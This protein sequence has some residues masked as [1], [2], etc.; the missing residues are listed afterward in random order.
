MLE[1]KQILDFHDSAYNRGQVT[2]ERAADDLVFAWV[3]QW[4]D[5]LLGESQLQ[6][7]GEFNILRK[8]MRQI[9]SDLNANPVQVDFEPVGDN[10]NAADIMDG[11]YRT[12]TRQNTSIEAFDNANQENVV[13]GFGSWELENVQDGPDKQKIRRMPIYESCN[14]VYWDPNAKLKDKSDARWCSVLARYSEDGAADLVEGLTGERPAG[15]P[16]FRYPEESYVFPWVAEDKR[17][18]IGRFYHREVVSYE[19]HVFVDLMGNREEVDDVDFESRENELLAGGFDYHECIECER[20][21]VTRYIVSG[22]GILESTLVPGEHIPVVSVYGERAMVEG[23]EHYE[24]ITRLAKDPQR[25]RNFQLSY[26]ADIVSRS[27]RTKPIFTPEQISG[28]EHMY[29]EQG[30]DSNYPYLLQNSADESGKPLPVG[31]VGTMPEQPIPD[32]LIASIDLS[33]QAVEDVANPGLPQNIADPDLSGKAVLA[34]QHRMDMQSFI[35]QN[36]YKHALRRDAEIFASMA[37]EVYDSP[38]KAT[39]TMADGSRKTEGLMQQRLNPRMMEMETINDLTG[40]AMEVYA[41]IGTNYAT[42]KQE[43]RMDIKELVMSMPVDDAMRSILMLEYISM[44]PGVDF[45]G[46]RKYANNELIRAGI[47]EPETEEEIRFA[48][49]LQQQQEQPDPA[50]LAAMAEMEKA[51]AEHA[52]A[53]VRMFDAQ[54]KRAKVEIDA[55]KAGVEIDSLNEDIAKK[56]MENMTRLAQTLRPQP[57]R[58]PAGIP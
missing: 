4:D 17:V 5:Q 33:R 31:P 47:R 21:E 14:A 2:R 3:T 48:Q 6:Y 24:G 43:T 42:E 7:R 28:F 51:Q 12:S 27:P 57:V 36:N 8:A 44:T 1:H 58:Q 25:L 35:Y 41:E 55:S 52:N 46:L 9:I 40:T 49:A 45:E 11:M 26:L 39:L 20:H 30:A 18:Y 23:D 13:A 19:V 56:R 37:R 53:E 38:R 34:L 29:E 54:T 50:T 16:S 15:V 22:S 10:Y 32:A